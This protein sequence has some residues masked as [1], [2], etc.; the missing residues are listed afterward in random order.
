M[1]KSYPQ[2]IKDHSCSRYQVEKS[3]QLH[4]AHDLT[5]WKES[6]VLM[7]WASVFCRNQMSCIQLPDTALIEPPRRRVRPATSFGV[8]V[9]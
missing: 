4:A 7:R 5:P 6:Q 1:S 8:A 3:C 2:T 9:R